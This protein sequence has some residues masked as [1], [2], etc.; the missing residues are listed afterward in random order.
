MRTPLLTLGLV[1]GAGCQHLDKMPDLKALL[2]KVRF[3]DMLV[4]DLSFQKLDGK[5]VLEVDNPYPVGLALKKTDWKLS[6]AGH[7]FLDGSDSDG[8]DIDPAATGKVRIPFSMKFVDAFQVAADL[9]DADQIPFGLET[10]LGFDTPVGPITVPLRHQGQLPALHAPKVRL[11]ALRIEK[12]NLLKNEASLALD[13][14]LHSDQ[15]SA[16]NFESFAWGLK[17]AGSDVASGSTVIGEV[18]GDKDVTLPIDLNLL[19]IGEVVLGA[20]TKKSEL[21]VRLSADAKVG[22]PF[23]VVPL[24]I[25]ELADLTPR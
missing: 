22:T 11:K 3:G 24:A 23:G 2:P 5:M 9:G 15:P 17:L 4:E 6:L 1:L 8:L 20:L 21:K 12:L 25:D 10:E 7:P 13:L 19:G 16:L 14:G 18:L